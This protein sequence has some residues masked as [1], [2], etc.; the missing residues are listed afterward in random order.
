MIDD[1]HAASAEYEARPHENRIADF[2]GDFHSI[3]NGMRD[4]AWRLSYAHFSDEIAEEVT[5]F[6]E[7]DVLGRCAENLDTCR[8]KSLG[9]IERGLSPELDDRAVAPFALVDFHHVLERER[10]EVEAVGGVVVG[11][12]GLGVG[13]DHHDFDPQLAERKR[14]MAAA[15]VELDALADTVRPAAKDHDFRG[16]WF[17]ARSSW[18]MVRG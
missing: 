2:G 18:I 17:V 10:L 14:R 6:G 8:F 7:R 12:D 3:V 5:V 1:R 16:S 13:V 4:A 9:E 11:R 15:P